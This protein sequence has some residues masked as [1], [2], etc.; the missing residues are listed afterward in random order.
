M[1]GK[2]IGA[3]DM[4][5]AVA[6]IAVIVGHSEPLGVPHGVISWCFSFHMPLFLIVSGFFTHADARPDATLVRK[7]A[8]SLLLPYA[9][10]CGIVIL[11]AALRAA[12]FEPGDVLSDIWLF[13][14]ASLWGAGGVI[15]GMPDGVI[16]IG[17]IWFLLAL[18][19]GKL[20]LAAANASPCPLVVVLCLLVAGASSDGVWLP[21]S[22]QPGMA[23]TFFLYVGQ[24]TREL[25]LL[26]PD[27]LH[28]LLWGAMTVTWLYAA[29]SYGRLYMFMAEF[30]DGLIDIVASICGSLVVIKLCM[31][32]E[33]RAPRATK[34]L[35]S[36][37]AITLPMLCAHL[38][39]LD[40]F[41]WGAVTPIL[42]SALPV[43][44]PISGLVLRF[45]LV[46]ALM[47]FLYV[48]PRPISGAF[49]PARRKAQAA[50]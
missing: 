50:A 30:D 42:E 36:L 35:A 45:A 39:E 9:I 3:I 10:T 48:L 27:A 43:P 47:A 22:L 24:K 19:W 40:V 44:L 49:Y 13:T 6:M 1:A 17:A 20:F 32:A 11:L 15:P 28:P 21:L 12:V 29:A 16:G 4:A 41:P 38:I 23:A 7:L 33:Q 5:K 14:E 25:R 18:F 2:R 31:L 37:G 46:A 26:E 34:P 8:K